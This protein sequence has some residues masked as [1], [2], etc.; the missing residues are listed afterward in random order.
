MIYVP[1]FSPTAL[2]CSVKKR[3]QNATTTDRDGCIRIT[4]I[5]HCDAA[6]RWYCCNDPCNNHETLC[7][8]IYPLQPANNLIPPQQYVLSALTSAQCLRDE[9]CFFSKP[10]PDHYDPNI[11]LGYG[12]VKVVISAYPNV[13]S[14]TFGIIDTL[15][16]AEHVLLS[17]PDVIPYISFIISVSSSIDH[18]DVICA[19]KA[20][21]YIANVFYNSNIGSHLQIKFPQ[22]LER[23]L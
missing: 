13:H 6:R 17:E 19:V 3:I 21:D 2:L 10:E 14:G 16:N 4:V 20:A 1:N 9:K 12:A 15:H 18:Q 5:P 7:E 8:T 11:G 22:S 23:H